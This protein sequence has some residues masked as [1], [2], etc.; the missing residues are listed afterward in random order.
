M[1]SLCYIKTEDRAQK[2][3]DR[4][5]GADLFLSSDLCSLLSDTRNL[6]PETK[7][8]MENFDKNN[9]T[10]VKKKEQDL[11]YLRG[12]C[13]VCNRHYFYRNNGICQNCNYACA[14]IDSKTRF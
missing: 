6:T 7:E 13:R 4:G 1:P 11:S 8:D 5:Q 2:T 9:T 10:R 14:R 3:D 12:Y